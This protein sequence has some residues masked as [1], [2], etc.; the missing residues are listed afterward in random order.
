L[1]K[2]LIIS[3][4]FPPSNAADMQRIRMSL[5]YFKECGWEVEVVCV[6][7]KH[8]EMVKD[9][10]FS[11]SIPKNIK[12]HFVSAFSKKWTSKFGLGSLALRSMWFYRRKVNQLIKKTHFDLIYFSTTQFP[13]TILGNYWKQKFRI[14]YVIDMQDPWH[15]DYYKDKPKDQRPAKYWF[16][17][18]LNKYLE[19]LAMKNIDGLISV[20]EAYINT[21]QECYPRIQN[22]PVAVIT[23]GAFEKDFEIAKQ[24]KNSL[25]PAFERK[26]GNIHIVYVGRGGHDMQ[27]SLYLLFQGF[28][29]GLAENSELFQ[30]M[31][32]HFIGTSYA[33]AGKGKPTILPIAIKLGLSEYINEQT[34]RIAFYQGIKTLLEADALLVP[35]SNDPKYTASKIYPYILAKKPLL[36]IF[37]PLSNASKIIVDCKAGKVVNMTDQKKAIDDI[38]YFLLSLTNSIPKSNNTNWEVFKEFTAENMTQ[39]QCKLFDR[40]LSSKH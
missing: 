36:A 5:P 12:I 17:Y 29:R 40:V 1:K 39:K 13:I 4:Y 24:E 6:D 35:G 15:S 20:S 31:R 2:A 22:I 32:F 26:N 27:D 21:L 18:R 34:D 25:K 14:P 33:P 11:E 38:Y 10:L 28:K 9:P 37:N 30:K 8:S 7:E 16:S 23:F 19:P 3:P